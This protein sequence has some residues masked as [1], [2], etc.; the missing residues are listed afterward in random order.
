MVLGGGSDDCGA[1]G[2]LAARA[3][4]PGDA[5]IHRFGASRGEDDFDGV[6]VQGG[7][8]ALTRVFEQTA[9]GLPRAVDRRRVADTLRRGEP[10]LPR[11]GTQGRRRGMVEV[12]DHGIPPLHVT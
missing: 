9:C 1:S 3:V 10:R 5:E 7:R 12:H 6:A 2:H 8:E 11:L 4:Q